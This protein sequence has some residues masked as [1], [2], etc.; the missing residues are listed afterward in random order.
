VCSLLWEQLSGREH[1]LFY[2]RLKNLKGKELNQVRAPHLSE[3]SLTSEL[4]DLA[5]KE[6]NT[7][8]AAD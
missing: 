5:R 4:V 7:V 6:N 2:G 1:L 8:G 3:P